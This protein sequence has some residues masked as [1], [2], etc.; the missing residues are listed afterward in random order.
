M[1]PSHREFCPQML[2]ARCQKPGDPRGMSTPVIND[3]ASNLA[4]KDGR[5]I[6][7]HWTHVI[8]IMANSAWIRAPPP[9]EERTMTLNLQDPQLDLAARFL[10]SMMA[11]DRNRTLA[12]RDDDIDHA[13]DVAEE[14]IRRRWSRSP[15]SLR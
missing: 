7:C 15:S 3:L 8:A 12:D 4:T 6:K 1:K 10:G 9:R 13:L 5:P 11:M 14:L 2:M